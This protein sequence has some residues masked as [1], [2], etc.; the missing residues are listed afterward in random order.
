MKLLALRLCEHDSN[1]SYFDGHSLHY[2]KS[3]R[4]FK[5]K[6]HGFSN[7]WEW[8]FIIKKLWN[9]D[10]K[11]ID[12]IV[13]IFDPWVH[14]LPIDNEDFF[15]DIIYDH[16]PSYKKPWRIS[17]HL[18]HS[19]STWM[20]VD[21]HIDVSFVFDGYGD[22]DRSFSVFKNNQLIEFGS[23]EYNG[24]LGTELAH[25]GRYLGVN[26]AVDLDLAG[27][28]MG[29]QSYGEIDYR[30]LNY[31][32]KFDIYNIK[33]IFNL[34]HYANH[35]GDKLLANL[36]PLNWI[37]TVHERVGDVLLEF[38][39]K[40]ANK[41]DTISYTGGVAQN[42][43]WNTKLKNHFPNLIIPPHC[44][45][46]GLS[47]GGIEWLRLKHQLP[48]F[49][50]PEFPFCQLDKSTEIITDDNIRL[51]AK[52]LAEGKSVA[53]YQGKGEIGPRALGNR[54]LLL[55][56][57]LKNGKDIMNSIKEREMY[58]P[59]GAV[60]L[61]EYAETLFNISYPNP[62]MLYV[63]HCSKDLFPSVTHIDGTCRVQT[64]SNSPYHLKLLLEEFNKITGCPVLL[65]TSLN[66]AG[67][68]MAGDP[69]EALELFY[70]S[71]LDVLAIGNN[72]FCK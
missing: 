8:K 25:A 70:N 62:Y 38:F 60:V 13:I 20:L 72:I 24:S 7:L 54:S 42:V 40:H 1:I 52:L 15:P 17:H 41:T 71:P 30:Y 27:K 43:L 16:F 64:V 47:L 21:K 14:N 12:D 59:F 39:K 3:E 34:S 36:L 45:D 23:L 10:E 33:E 69:N 61:E 49:N 51:C 2:F 67:K 29:L 50:I 31:L 35:I 19:L 57:R 9:I 56:P 65:N 53:W 28:V 55:D 6:H 22:R 11:D 5:L 63:G 48:K 26:A 68:P 58:R 4:W 46:D 66:L 44:A 37:K 32:D 18:A